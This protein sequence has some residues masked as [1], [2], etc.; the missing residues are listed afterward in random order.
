M[1]CILLRQPSNLVD[2]LLNLKTFQVVKLRL[3]ALEGAVNIVL[4]A[5]LKLILT[6][7][8]KQIK[9]KFKH[10]ET[11]IQC[12]GSRSQETLYFYLYVFVLYKLSL[13][14]YLLPEYYESNVKNMYCF[15]VSL[16]HTSCSC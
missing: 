3:V 12:L 4:S 11:K 5:A 8:T 6:L 10:Y 9:Q 2:L 7:N 16:K 14:T 15:Y 13:M 1:C